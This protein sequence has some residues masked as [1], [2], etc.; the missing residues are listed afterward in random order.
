[1][2]EEQFT[3]TDW[4]DGL[5]QCFQELVDYERWLEGELFR[6]RRRSENALGVPD[7]HDDRDDRIR[8][9]TSGYWRFLGGT[10]R[11][12][13]EYKRSVSEKLNRLLEV[14]LDHPTLKNAVYR[15]GDGQLSLGLNLGVSRSAGH[16]LNVMLMGLVDHAVEHGPQATADALAQVIQRGD[17]RDLGSY[18]I[19]LFRGLHVERRHD[20]PNGLS[21]VS[22]EEVRRYL[23]DDRVRQMLEAADTE[24]NREPIGAVVLKRKWGPVFVPAGYDMDGVDWPERSWTFRDDALLLLD[25]LAVVHGFPVSSSRTH[26]SVVERQIEHLVGLQP[27]FSRHVRDILGVNT[28]R[29]EPISTPAVSEAKLSD[30]EQLLFSCRDNVQMRLALSRLASSLGRTGVHEAL[31]KVIDVAIALEVMYQLDA[32]HGKGSKLSSRARN[33]IGGDRED[34][35]WIDRTGESV[36]QAR[37][38]IVHDGTLPTDA[39]QIYEDAFELSRRTLLHVAGSGRS[40]RWGRL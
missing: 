37:N 21:I 8:E 35:R 28:T 13:S 5:S 34:R 16:Q 23:A 22:F 15:A 29:I 39:D 2:S 14:I 25:V 30:C 11:A 26:T 18:Q 20:F 31:D 7:S 10:P 1:M 9:R 38:S 32:S 3:L 33:L 40:I 36:F 24:I 27:R 17:D 12:D 6:L 19:L 4:V